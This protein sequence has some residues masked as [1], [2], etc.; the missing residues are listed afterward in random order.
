MKTLLKF[1]IALGI[2]TNSLIAGLYSFIITINYLA[3]KSP[4]DEFAITVSTAFIV[5]VFIVNMIIAILW[6]IF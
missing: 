6:K 4:Q 2:Y 3:M 1:L 5:G